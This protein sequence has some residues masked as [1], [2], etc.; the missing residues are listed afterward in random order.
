MSGDTLFLISLSRQ[1]SSLVVELGQ[2]T[3]ERLESVGSGRWSGERMMRAKTDE[4]MR[5]PSLAAAAM[6]LE[7]EGI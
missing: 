5:S 2:P 7:G 3:L 4:G 6:T 1:S